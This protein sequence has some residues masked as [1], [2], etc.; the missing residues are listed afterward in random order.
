MARSGQFRGLLFPTTTGTGRSDFR[1]GHQITD[2]FLQE[3]VVRVELVVFFFDGL[4]AIEDGE[5]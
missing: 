3:L 2:V 5:D 1:G 4:D